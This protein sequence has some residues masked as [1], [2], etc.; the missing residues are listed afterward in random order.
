[1]NF[2]TELWEGLCIAW[3]AIRANKLRSVLTTLGIVIGVITV[4]LMGTAI[5]GLNNSF[6]NSISA[7]GADVLYAQKQDWFIESYK[8]WLESQK[9]PPVGEPELRVLQ[10]DMTLAAAIAPVADSAYPVKYGRHSSG[11]V[12]VYGT[13]EQYLPASGVTVERGRFLSAAEC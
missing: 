9:R 1:M 13:T 10:K 3:D 11:S 2:L 8:D 12:P 4:T 6:L 7:I 5:N